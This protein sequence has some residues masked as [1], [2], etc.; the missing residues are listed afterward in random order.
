MGNTQVKILVDD[1]EICLRP[2]ATL[3]EIQVVYGD[4]VLRNNHDGSYFSRRD[5]SIPA[6]NYTFV[7]IP[8]SSELKELKIGERL[9][10]IEDELK[11]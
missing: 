1:T 2:R 6:G 10:A 8:M 3:A 9:G 4:G 11:E 7:R 5:K